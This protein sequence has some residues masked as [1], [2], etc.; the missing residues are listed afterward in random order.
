MAM[1]TTRISLAR[2]RELNVPV[3]WQEAVAVARAAGNVSLGTGHGASLETCEITTSGTVEIVGGARLN[4]SLR[5]P[6]F[7]LLSALI[8]GQSAP[9]ALR[10]LVVSQKPESDDVLMDFLSEDEPQQDRE[11]LHDLSFFERPNPELLIAA[12]A[13]RGLA[14]AEDASREIARTE[15]TDLAP[16]LLD[17]RSDRQQ[18]F[19]AMREWVALRISPLALG[20]GALVVVVGA[21]WALSSR[22]AAGT[23]MEAAVTREGETSPLPE[24]EPPV[25]TP[26]TPALD[27]P[28]PT[29][30]ADAPAAKRDLRERTSRVDAAESR[31]AE[32]ASATIRG[33]SASGSS[34]SATDVPVDRVEAPAPLVVLPL[35]P[36]AA[37]EPASVAESGGAVEI[38]PEPAAPEIDEPVGYAAPRIYSAADLDVVPPVMVRPQVA[39]EPRIDT[40]PSQAEIELVINAEGI[41]TRVRLRTDGEL[42][43]NDRMIVA[44]AKA[45]V[46]YPALKDGRPVSYTLRIP[47]AP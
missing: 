44:A 22:P 35:L 19:A 25:E 23:T 30:R 39:S 27:T 21:A 37:R 3:H 20:A 18:V 31:R 26:N 40:E 12:L 38:E 16:Q 4:G 10:A 2:I 5:T 32:M 24:A 42:S 28:A 36:S 34:A 15:S 33:S 45:W 11:P 29:P 14:A 17:Q 1:S 46:F 7:S 43:L 9:D 13:T 41:V 6:I 8:D 47:V